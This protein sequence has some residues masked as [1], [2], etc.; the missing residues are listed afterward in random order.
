MFSHRQG[1][2]AFLIVYVPVVQDIDKAVTGTMNL[3]GAE[4]NTK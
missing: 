1:P 3:F 4:V 2:L